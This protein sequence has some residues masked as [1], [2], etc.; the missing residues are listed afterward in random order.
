MI[1][2]PRLEYVMLNFNIF[3]PQIILNQPTQNAYYT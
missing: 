2:E 1:E 3:K